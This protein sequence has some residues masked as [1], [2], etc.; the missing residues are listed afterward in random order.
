MLPILANNQAELISGIA[1]HLKN[2]G[3]KKRL[4]KVIKKIKLEFHLTMPVVI[5]LALNETCKAK[6]SSQPKIKILIHQ[7]TTHDCIDHLRWAALVPALLGKPELEIE[8]VGINTT[9]IQDNISNARVLIDY[10][11]DKEELG[12]SFKSSLYE[13]DIHHVEDLTTYDLIINNNAS[14]VDLFKLSESNAMLA[15]VDNEI[16]YVLGDFSQGTILNNYNLLR[17]NGFACKGNLIENQ[18]ATKFNAQI[19][20]TVYGHARYLLSINCKTEHCGEISQNVFASYLSALRIRLDHGDQ[21]SMKNI[22]KKINDTQVQIFPD[23]LL[24]V[25][26]CT[27]SVNHFGTIYNLPVDESLTIIP[28][29]DD[30]LNGNADKLLWATFVYLQLQQV[31]NSKQEKLA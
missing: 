6:L 2:K 26:A 30:S 19:R 9:P 4:S 7:L 1:S 17:N 10:I 15:I 31:I 22:A 29:S 21:L 20:N 14:P 16:P 5:A 11:I 3:A 27:A 24:D 12:S 18:F 13:A 25:E 8:V 23:V 28:N